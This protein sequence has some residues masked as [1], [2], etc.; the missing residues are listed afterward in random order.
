MEAPSPPLQ[1]E[2]QARVPAEP[3]SGG[4]TIPAQCV[5]IEVHVGEL[6]Q[7]F[8]SI[9][10][11]P[12]RERDLDPNTEEF[13]VGWAREAG[14]EARLGLLVHLDRPAGPPNEP[15]AL[16]DAVHEYFRERARAS[17]QRLRLLLRRGRIALLIGL[18]ALATSLLLGDL[19]AWG[20]EGR[21]IGEILR[22][23]LLIGGWVAMWRPLEVF[24]YDWWPI[25][26]EARLYDRLA[27]M[28]VQIEYNPQAR[29]DAWRSDWPAVPPNQ[30]TG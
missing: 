10:P 29:P 19:I 28:P 27:A 8:N 1:R 4:D 16:R 2:R 3:R 14:R 21:R 13:I 26:D 24:L 11:S 23:S 18:F 30:K 22:E 15:N 7:L 17:R 6:K 12:F 25:R 9:D 5:L 20:L